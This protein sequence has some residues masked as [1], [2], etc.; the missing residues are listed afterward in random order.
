M[1]GKCGETITGEVEQN[2]PIT[3]VASIPTPARRDARGILVFDVTL[4]NRTERTIHALTAEF[5]QIYV[6]SNRLI[7]GEPLGVRASGRM[8]DL[9]PGE[10][11]T[12]KAGANF[13]ACGPDTA[14]GEKLKNGTYELFAYLQVQFVGADLNLTGEVLDVHAGPWPVSLTGT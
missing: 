9:K 12:L 6:T 14:G 8:V 4:T 3:M 5:P 10:S 11:F 7:V 1:P 2:P 13:S